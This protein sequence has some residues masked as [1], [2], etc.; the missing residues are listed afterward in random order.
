MTATARTPQAPRKA[1]T[2]AYSYIRFSTPE[3]RKGDSLRRQTEAAQAWCDRNNARLDVATTLHDLGTSAFRGAHRKSP[4]RNNLAAF[5][6]LVEDSKVPRGSYLIIESL[7]RLTREHIRPALTLLLNLI[8]AGVRI[9]QLK[10]VE[11]IYDDETLEPMTLMM[12]LMELSRGN[13]ESKMKSERVGAAWSNKRVQARNG[14]LATRNL[15]AWVRIKDMDSDR[16]TLELIPKRAEVV[17]RIFK[18][19]ASGLGQMRICQILTQDGVAAW[20][21]PTN[22]K[23]IAEYE[24]RRRAEGKPPL[25]AKERAAFDRPGYWHRGEWRTPAWT[26]GYV[27]M[28]LRDRR[29]LGEYLP[30]AR[31]GLADGSAIVDYFPTVVDETTFNAARA[32]LGKRKT[33]TGRAQAHVAQAGRRGQERRVGRHVDLF[34][35]LILDT[36]DGGAYYAATRTDN[37]A[38]RYYDADGK[39]RRGKASGRRQTRVLVTASAGEGRGPA[40]SFPLPTFERAVLM[41]MREIDAREVLGEASPAAE[42]A[43][44]ERQLHWLADRQA[45]LAAE[46]RD[47]DIPVI[48]QQLRELTAEENE[49]TAQLDESRQRVAKPLSESWRDLNSL[50]DQTGDPDVRRRI[51]FAAARVVEEIR[52]TVVARGRDRLAAVEVVFRN[53]YRRQLLIQHR[54]IRGNDR[55]TTPGWFRV[56]SAGPKDLMRTGLTLF[57]SSMQALQAREDQSVPLVPGDEGNENHIPGFLESLTDEELDGLFGDCPKQPLP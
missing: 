3:Q 21:R 23:K 30:R 22:D 52:L 46:L 39:R 41:M 24:E 20:G 2:V 45:E 16:C 29:A 12:A 19:A 50:I 43:S 18:L 5:L 34:S 28:I 36:V 14:K 27:G 44:L 53:R 10:P 49:V 9:V 55:V 8:E 56:R 11:V 31:R 17:A 1:G 7:D 6:K 51:R 37:L 47:G 15:P 33:G 40:R 54:A 48:A 4:D 42:V 13:S 57:P 35:G 26:R 32:A 25:T 38:P